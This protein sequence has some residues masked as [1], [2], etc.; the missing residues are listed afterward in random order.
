MVVLSIAWV[1]VGAGVAGWV[2]LYTA[3]CWPETDPFCWL[4][5]GFALLAALF[6]MRKEY[7]WMVREKLGRRPR[8]REALGYWLRCMLTCWVLFPAGMIAGYTV[9]RW[10][11][12]PPPP[13]WADASPVDAFVAAA[14]CMVVLD[15]W[16]MMILFSVFTDDPARF[17]RPGRFWFQIIWYSVHLPLLLSIWYYVPAWVIASR[18][19]VAAFLKPLTDL[20]YYYYCARLVAMLVLTCISECI[21]D[22]IFVL[23]G[24]AD[25]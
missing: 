24:L 9:Y 22:E 21:L 2:Y 16:Y 18:P 23:F 3:A 5:R 1:V 6:S 14:G 4:P 15:N 25:D 10:F 19:E 7:K 20:S 17:E 11:Q 13:G 8:I 12:A